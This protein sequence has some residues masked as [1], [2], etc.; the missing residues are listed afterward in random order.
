MVTRPFFNNAGLFIFPE[1]FIA[2]IIAG[3][4]LYSGNIEDQRKRKDR[5]R[6]N[7]CLMLI[8]I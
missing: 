1:M 7:L 5:G 3:S 6:S 2:S 4:E 8:D